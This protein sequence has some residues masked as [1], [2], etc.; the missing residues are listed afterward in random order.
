MRELNFEELQQIE[1]GGWLDV[2]KGLA[3]G[4]L[5][6]GAYYVGGPIAAIWAIRVGAVGACIALATS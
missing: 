1:G 3:C 2:A 4:G 6:V 5:L